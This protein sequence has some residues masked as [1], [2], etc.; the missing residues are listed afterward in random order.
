MD[1]Y[2]KKGTTRI[3]IPRSFHQFERLLSGT[4]DIGQL[5]DRESP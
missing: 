5:T 2:H 3:L 4:A 1:E